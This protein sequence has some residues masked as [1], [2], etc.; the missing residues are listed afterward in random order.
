MNKS[1]ASRL[2]NESNNY[3]R[4]IQC[5]SNEK[6]IGTEEGKI[7][8]GAMMALSPQNSFKNIELLISLSHVAFL[9]DACVQTGAFK[10]IGRY[11]TSA[12]KLHELL[13]DC[14]TGSMY[15]VCQEIL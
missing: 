5:M 1:Y 14:A 8:Y 2:K 11:K 9:R 15:E 12:S 10:N 7:I 13:Q 6:Y 3:R 4:M